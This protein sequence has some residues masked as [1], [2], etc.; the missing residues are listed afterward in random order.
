MGQWCQRIK[1]FCLLLHCLPSALC[2]T[3]KQTHKV[4][5]YNYTIDVKR[6][7]LVWETEQPAKFVRNKKKTRRNR[8]VGHGRP[9]PPIGSHETETW[10]PVHF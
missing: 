4:G 9:I 8:L 7:T 3:N 10:V 1:Q 6:H 2:D 5:L